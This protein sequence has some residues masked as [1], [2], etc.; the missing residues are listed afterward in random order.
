[1]TRVGSTLKNLKFGML[2][3]II[4]ILLNLIVRLIFLHYISIEYLGA[5]GL[6]SSIFSILS[7]TEA[8]IGSAITYSLYKPLSENDKESVISLMQLYKIS[9]R[10]IGTIVLVIGILLIPS[11]PFFTNNS[12]LPNLTLI[13]IMFLNLKVS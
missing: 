2:Y 6:F 1:M 10:C 4:T 12:T 8:G 13:Y 7:F 5:S 3:N 9:Y 11:L